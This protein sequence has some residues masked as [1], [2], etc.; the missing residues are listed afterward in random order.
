MTCVLC[1]SKAELWKRNKPVVLKIL[2]LFYSSLNHFFIIM[3]F[4]FVPDKKNG[5]KT[6]NHLRLPSSLLLHLSLLIQLLLHL[7]LVLHHQT[8]LVKV[9][10]D[11]LILYTVPA[12]PTLLPGPHQTPPLPHQASNQY[13]AAPPVFQTGKLWST[14]KQQRLAQKRGEN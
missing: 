2:I 3:T 7:P 4:I 8:K 14:K 13:L 10:K 9:I 11:R 6:I 1:K 12:L 5:K